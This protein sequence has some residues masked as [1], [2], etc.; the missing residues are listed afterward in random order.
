[1]KRI[2]DACI[3]VADKSYYSEL[4]LG[5]LLASIL[6]V[7]VMLAAAAPLFMA[8]ALLGGISY[9]QIAWTFAIT[10]S[11]VLVCGSLGSLLALWREKTFQ[12]I[13][14]TVLV[15]VLW[16]ARMEIVAAGAL[17]ETIA[18]VPSRVLAAD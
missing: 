9:R 10:L 6:N 11:S 16:G 14:L 17:G 5:K 18:G 7:I 1:M 2:A 15:I 4:V 12:A 3:V 13:A 8:V